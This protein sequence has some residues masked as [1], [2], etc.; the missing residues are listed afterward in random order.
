M[1]ILC[2]KALGYNQS[3]INTSA[4]FLVKE[5]KESKSEKMINYWASNK[6]DSYLE[7]KSSPGCQ[8]FIVI[9]VKNNSYFS[10]IAS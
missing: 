9:C 7:E 4:V 10:I 1:S 8:G 6:K 2:N 3:V 5:K